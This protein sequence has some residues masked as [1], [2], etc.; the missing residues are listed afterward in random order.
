MNVVLLNH[1][2][3]RVAYDDNVEVL[4]KAT[5]P[6]VMRDGVREHWRQINRDGKTAN[7]VRSRVRKQKEQAR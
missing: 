3:Y 5:G 6:R 1:R 7:A 4:I 2:L